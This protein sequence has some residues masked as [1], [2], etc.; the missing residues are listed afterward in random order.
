MDN[1]WVPF[2]RTNLVCLVVLVVVGVDSSA[3]G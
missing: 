1:V 2:Q 3:E